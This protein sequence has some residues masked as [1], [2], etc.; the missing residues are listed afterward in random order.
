MF[1]HPGMI[2][3]GHPGMAMMGHPGMVMLGQP[4]CKHCHEVFSSPDECTTPSD[5]HCVGCPRYLDIAAIKRL[6]QG[7]KETAG[8][9]ALFAVLRHVGVDFEEGKVEIGEGQGGKLQAALEKSL[10]DHVDE[11]KH[12]EMEAQRHL[13]E[14]RAAQLELTEPSTPP[15]QT[16]RG[17]S[18]A[19]LSGPASPVFTRSPLGGAAAEQKPAPQQKLPPRKL[20][21]Q[22]RRKEY[23]DAHGPKSLDKDGRPKEDGH[24]LDYDGVNHALR[25]PS[26][27]GDFTQDELFQIASS[28]N[29]VDVFHRVSKDKNLYGT[30]G[31]GE[32][33]LKLDQEICSVIEAG[34]GTLS[35]AAAARARRKIDVIL[36][37]KEQLPTKYIELER[38]RYTKLRDPDGKKIVRSNAAITDTN[39]KENKQHCDERMAVAKKESLEYTRKTR[40]AEADRE[41]ARRQQARERIEAAKAKTTKAES[42]LQKAKEANERALAQQLQCADSRQS[43]RERRSS[44]RHFMGHREVLESFDGSHMMG[45][46]FQSNGLA[47]GRELFRGPRGGIYHMSGENRV[48]HP[49]M[50]GPGYGSHGGPRC[51]DGSR[52]MR[53]GSNRGFDKWD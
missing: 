32:G 40:Q 52:D 15:R 20:F 27:P 8:R 30:K 2:M 33:H 51:L 38:R 46:T 13:N 36:A 37:S 29:D 9:D 50:S 53:F 28:I 45:Q 42:L 35:K 34:G 23:A 49:E 41:A 10:S 16:G 5:A 43:Q 1:H 47:N 14:C 3:M 44:E 48:Y 39:Y 26:S 24:L 31:S 22:R 12:T 7:V 25:D 11:R 4:M 21:D 18:V 6:M 17:C 19:R